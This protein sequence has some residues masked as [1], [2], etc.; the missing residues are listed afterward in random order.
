MS[1]ARL[2]TST[3]P[4][5]IESDVL[6]HLPD[7]VYRHCRRGHA[8]GLPG[9]VPVAGCISVLPCKGLPE[10]GALVYQRTLRLGWDRIHPSQVGLCL[11][12]DY[13]RWAD[14]F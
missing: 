13:L 5:S 4:A 10:V 6:T 8:H 11:E 14:R 9:V 7:R 1:Q 12:S 3:V 2:G